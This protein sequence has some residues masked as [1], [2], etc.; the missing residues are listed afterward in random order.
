V[1]AQGEPYSDDGMLLDAI[2]EPVRL[3]IVRHLADRAPATLAEIAD[4]VDVHL[5]TVRAHVA[6]LEAA[7]VLVAEPRPVPSRGRRPSEYR[8][9]ESWSLGATDFF[10]LA[11]LLTAA[12]VR[13]DL[14]EE[15][16]RELGVE[17]GRFLAGRP[18]RRDAAEAVPDALERLGFHA[19]VEGD[20]VLLTGCPCAL[21]SSD[22][23]QVVCTLAC[24][25]VDGVLGA[26]C[27]DRHV[28]EHDSDPAARSCRTKLG[29]R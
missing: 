17:W 11:E 23:P 12:L 21:L 29:P 19:Q 1:A 26:C 14:T 20:E 6:S 28:V 15:D 18:G 27:S 2:A 8:L 9:A 7:G 16:L 25:V 5:N 24:G 22:R 4:A 3:R 10:G 13:S